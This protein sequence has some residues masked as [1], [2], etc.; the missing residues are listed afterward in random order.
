MHETLLLISC[1]TVADGVLITTVWAVSDDLVPGHRR[2]ELETLDSAPKLLAR[3]GE[4]APLLFPA[5]L[6]ALPGSAP[7]ETAA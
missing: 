4:L 2:T 3:L 7:V 5:I 6:T 1:T